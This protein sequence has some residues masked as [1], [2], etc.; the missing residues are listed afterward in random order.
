MIPTTRRFQLRHNLTPAVKITLGTPSPAVGPRSDFRLWF[1]SSSKVR[2]RRHRRHTLGATVALN[3][4]QE[5]DV[6]FL[7]DCS[8]LLA[9]CAGC[10]QQR[11]VT[12]NV[13]DSPFSKKF[14]CFPVGY[15]R[16]PGGVAI[17][18]VHNLVV[19]PTRVAIRF[20][21]QSGPRQPNPTNALATPS[22]PARPATPYWRRR[23]S[24]DSLISGRL[25]EPR[26]SPGHQ[27]WLKHGLMIDLVTPCRSWTIPQRRNP[28]S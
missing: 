11:L 23:T 8:P 25:L 15:P 6:T 10:G 20:R 28:S 18:E 24:P 4:S 16:R 13:V 9:L 2:P 27:Q 3:G 26:A 22:K 14:L 21:L 5:L 1:S 17:D 19:V 12:S 7:L